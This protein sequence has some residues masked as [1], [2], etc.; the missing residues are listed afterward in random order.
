[1][2]YYLDRTQLKNPV[3]IKIL[4]ATFPE[5]K[6]R[7]IR[8][9]TGDVFYPDQSWSGGSR[10]IWKL[11]SRDGRVFDPGS[12]YSSGLFNPKE[13]FNPVKIPPQCFIVKH[14]IFCGRDM[15]ITILVRPEEFD[16]GMLPLPEELSANE[17]IV[18]IATRSLKSS[19][20]GISNYRYHEAHDQ[21]GITLED[22]NSAVQS[23]IDKGY[24]TKNKSITPKG[25][26]QVQ[27]K[28]LYEMRKKWK[29]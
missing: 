9:S 21:T 28:S 18:L 3:L 15:G 26:N 8:V 20:A 10:T 11:V 24:L 7:T 6:G 13:A 1:M 19:Y 25:K 29:H 12:T 23:C 16:T 22:W 17:M 27:N 14:S 4:N 5:Y 2:N